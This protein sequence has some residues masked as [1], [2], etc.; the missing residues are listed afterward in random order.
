MQLVAF[1]ILHSRY[2]ASVSPEFIG[3]PNTRA[4]LRLTRRTGRCKGNLALG[5][6]GTAAPD[7]WFKRECCILPQAFFP[8]RPT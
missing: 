6:R 8:P 4:S 5:V 3:V 1:R 2:G 7:P